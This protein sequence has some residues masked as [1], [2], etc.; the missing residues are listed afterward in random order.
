VADVVDGVFELCLGERPL[1]PVCPRLALVGREVEEAALQH[2]A[3]SEVAV[4]GLPDDQ[5][6]EI[7][8]AIVVVAHGEAITLEILAAHC[9]TLIASYKKPRRL[10]FVDELPKMVSG[11]VDKKALRAAYAVTA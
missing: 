1:P 11:K 3:V 10:V 4:I 2:S 6:G 8:C 9:Q 5:W 7:V